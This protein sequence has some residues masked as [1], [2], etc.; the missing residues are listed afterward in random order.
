M[1]FAGFRCSDAYSNYEYFRSS[2]IKKD[3]PVSG[4]ALA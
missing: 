2:D 3:A 1:Q 4:G